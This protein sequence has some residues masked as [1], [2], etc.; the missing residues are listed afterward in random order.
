VCERSRASR[1]S[2][3]LR[4]LPSGAG[5][6]REDSSPAARLRATSEPRAGVN[7]AA[8]PPTYA[9]VD[10]RRAGRAACGRLHGG[11]SRPAPWAGSPRSRGSSGSAWRS[12]LVRQRKRRLS[13]SASS[14]LHGK[15]ANSNLVK[16][17]RWFPRA[18]PALRGDSA[19]RSKMPRPSASV[20]AGV[21]NGTH[22]LSTRASNPPPN[23]RFP[24]LSA[25]NDPRHHRAG[26]GRAERGAVQ[27]RESFP[28]APC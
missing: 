21:P 17:G 14:P 5:G 6:P 2:G 1:T 22:S 11:R 9:F 19:R 18:E 26:R 28:R 15:R 25:K 27:G 12:R 23:L 10:R 16:P 3:I 4:A 24:S 7:A 8:R 13:H 20:V